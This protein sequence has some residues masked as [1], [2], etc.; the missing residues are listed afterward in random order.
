[1]RYLL[2]D[3]LR[4]VIDMARETGCWQILSI[5]ERADLVTALLKEYPVFIQE[6]ER[7]GTML[8]FSRRAA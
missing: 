8:A 3:L 1:M 2:R 7:S 4:D 6:I 5:R